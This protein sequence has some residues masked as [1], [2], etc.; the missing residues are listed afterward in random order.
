VAPLNVHDEIMTVND[1]PGA[2]AA[3]VRQA[4]ESYR[5]VVPLI[6][7]TWYGKLSDW[8]DKENGLEPMELK[9]FLTN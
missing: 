6:A 9:P 4:V 1:C 8:S 3:A 5:P 7:M 2:V